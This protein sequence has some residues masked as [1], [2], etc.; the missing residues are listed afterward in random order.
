M[1]EYIPI[2]DNDGFI[3]GNK[4]KFIDGI[5]TLVMD[6]LPD[7]LAKLSS[8]IVKGKSPGFKTAAGKSS[9]NSII[10]KQKE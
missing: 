2:P 1:S 4:L 7:Y 5:I 3:R 6:D 9:I 10:K 8:L